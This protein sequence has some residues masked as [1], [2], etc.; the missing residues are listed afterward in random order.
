VEFR[1]LGHLE[2]RTGGHLLDIGPARQRS[3]LAALVADANRPVTADQLLDRVWGGARPARAH[4]ALYSYL[5]RIRR[6]LPVPLVRRYGGYVL[7]TE[8]VD[9]HRFRTLVTHARLAGNDEEALALFDAA[10]GLWRGDAFAAIDTPWF[11]AV[12]ETLTRQRIA[13]ERDRADVALRLG[14]HDRLL[15]ELPAAAVEHPL[16]ERLAGQI[17]LALS[18]SG[19]HANA[20]DHYQ[21]FREL[22]ADRLGVDPSPALRQLHMRVLTATRQ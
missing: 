11:D 21:R 19:H 2:A 20:L 6:L 12:R 13:A 17:I 16:D 8:A 22:L 1:V 7:A 15:A 3:V 4:H 5:S 9:L 10:L 14:R 18:R